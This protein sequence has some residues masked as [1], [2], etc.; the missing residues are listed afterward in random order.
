MLRY[1]NFTTKSAHSSFAQGSPVHDGNMPPRYLP[2]RGVRVNGM[3]IS[4]LDT[5]IPER[6]HRS[7]YEGR[8]ISKSNSF[9]C[10]I[11]ALL[12]AGVDIHDYIGKGEIKFN[13]TDHIDPVDTHPQTGDI[14]DLG[15]YR[16]ADDE[17]TYV[18]TVFSAPQPDIQSCLHKLGQS[19]PVCISSLH[20]AQ[21]I[22]N[23][24]IAK[25]ISAFCLDATGVPPLTWNIE[26]K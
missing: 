2:L 7:I 12:M 23:A 14:I 10:V 16:S 18:H 9:D 25:Q 5:G 15:S 11:F 13:V 1:I 21:R 4:F 19:G 6:L 22:Y 26:T 17:P 8:E 3:P 24:P 20:D